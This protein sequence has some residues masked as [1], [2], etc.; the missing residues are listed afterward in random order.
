L[1]SHLLI[2]P[3]GQPVV[4]KTGIPGNFDISL[5]YA[6]PT[7]TDSDQPSI[8]VAI[9]EQLGLQLEPQKVPVEMI[10]IDKVDKVPVEN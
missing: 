5:K 6:Q 7:D 3:L 1:L 8:F 10:V 4:N 9:K 2:V